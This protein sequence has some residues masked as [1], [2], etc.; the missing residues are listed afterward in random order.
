[1]SSTVV[2]ISRLQPIP[3]WFPFPALL[4]NE[5]TLI[6]S[7]SSPR[8]SH[9]RTS[10]DFSNNLF[11]HTKNFHTNNEWMNCP[12]SFFLDSSAQSRKEKLNVWSI[13]ENK[14]RIAAIESELQCESLSTKRW[15]FLSFTASFQRCYHFLD[16]GGNFFVVEQVRKSFEATLK[17]G[18]SGE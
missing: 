4:I 5:W 8:D 7:V 2:A 15:K 3:K 17:H 11:L 1:M 13:V 9:L 12:S 6:T 16:L 14:S 18:T 10:R